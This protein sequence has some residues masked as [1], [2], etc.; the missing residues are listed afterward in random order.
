M[1]HP[2]VEAVARAIFAQSHPD[3]D[4]NDDIEID[5]GH[6]KWYHDDAT[7]AIRALLDVPVSSG[8]EKAGGETIT[9]GHLYPGELEEIFTTMLTQLVQEIEGSGG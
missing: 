7:A 3:L 2:A 4:W 1:T 9:M 6:R 8:M 5:E